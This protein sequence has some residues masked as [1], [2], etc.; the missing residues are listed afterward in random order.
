MRERSQEGVWLQC[1]TAKKIAKW[2][3]RTAFNKERAL[4]WKCM[5]LLSGRNST[6]QAGERE[7]VHNTQLNFH[8][9]VPVAGQPS[10]SIHSHTTHGIP[11]KSNVTHT[12]VKQP[13]SGVVQ[14]TYHTRTKYNSRRD[15]VSVKENHLITYLLW[16]LDGNRNPRSSPSKHKKRLHTLKYQT[17]QTSQVSSCSQ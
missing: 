15:S 2:C 13:F 5:C 4:L 8:T 17:T 11:C 7:E 16:L 12:H 1:K 6:S 9:C 10:S 14:C 3:G